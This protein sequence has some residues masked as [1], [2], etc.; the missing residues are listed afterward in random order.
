MRKD[1]IYLCKQISM[2]L[3]TKI[4]M[5]DAVC[6]IEK[7]NYNTKK[8]EKFKRLMSD[9]KHKLSE[10]LTVGSVFESIR[11]KGYIDRISLSI[12]KA[13]EKSSDLRLGFEKVYKRLEK[14]KQKEGQIITKLLYPIIVSV[15]SVFLVYFLVLLIFPKI[16]PL[17][18]SMGVPVPKT[19]R[20]ALIAVNTVT[21]NLV[22]ILVCFFGLA[23]MF[24]Y[25]YRKN[26]KFKL[27]VHSLAL[28]TPVISKILFARDSASVSYSIAVL[29]KSNISISDTISYV[30]ED[31]LLE[32]NKIV[33][34]KIEEGLQ[35][36]KEISETLN[37]TF[38]KNT[39]WADFIYIGERTGRLDESFENLST[40]YESELEEVLNYI[41]GFAEP[42]LL[43]C[44]ASVVLFIAL[45]VVQPMYSIIQYVNP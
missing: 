12:I 36:G 40:Y 3:S 45:S 26:N 5:Y 38:F 25:Q 35:N 4:S 42:F 23:S 1:I 7:K 19:T 15:S 13:S 11:D 37:N 30:K 39:D 10:G 20:L 29:L 18:S 17:F 8:S 32:Q 16:L 34:G 27:S 28:K 14:V 31:L 43:F 41:T 6:I 33:F 21:H 44:V 9:I 22:Y 24:Q 2:Y